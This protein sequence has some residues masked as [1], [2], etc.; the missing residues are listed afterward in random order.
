MIDLSEGWVPKRLI[1]D[2]GEPVLEMVLRGHAPLTKPFL[3]QDLVGYRKQ[4]RIPLADFHFQEAG[5]ETSRP[6]GFIF[7]MSRSGSTAA[8]RMLAAV[9]RHVV[10][11]E[12]NPLKDLFSSPSPISVEGGI[13]R[14]R[15]LIGVY[16]RGLLMPGQKLLIKWTSWTVLRLPGLD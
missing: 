13:E 11:V 4:Q 14:L 15:T 1:Y 3:Y 16:A 10:L 8:A 9:D 7:H 5:G 12:P 6:S 2:G